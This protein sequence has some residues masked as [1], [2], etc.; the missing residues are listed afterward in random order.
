VLV[1]EDR[2]D[3]SS[4]FMDMLKNDTRLRVEVIDNVAQARDMVRKGNKAAVVVVPEGFSAGAIGIFQGHPITLEL[5]VD[6]SRRAQAGMLEGL[7]TADAYAF[8]QS[9]LTDPA[10]SRKMT[11]E[12][13]E[14]L[15]KAAKT[16]D[17]SP[18]RKAVVGTFLKSLD[19]F[20]SRLPELDDATTDT[21]VGLAA[22]SSE[23][24][25]VAGFAPIA[26][27]PIP[28]TSDEHDDEPNAYAVSFPQGIA[29]GIMACSAA[30]ALSLV[31]ERTHGTL[32]RLAAAPMHRSSVLLGKGLACF[33]ATITTALVLLVIARFGFGVVPVSYGLLA[34]A[35]FSGAIAF[36]GIMMLLSV[37]GK[38]EASAGGIGWAALIVMSMFGGGMVPL[39]FMKGWMQSLSNLSPVK[40]L[41]YSLEGAIWRDLGFSQ[42]LV[43]CG[44]LIAVGCVGYGLGSWLFAR[45]WKA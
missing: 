44:I 11:R 41:I 35:V 42:M 45:S 27:E 34:L 22:S 36:V 30:F 40:W 38:T 19:V 15:D 9:Q 31:T 10:Q 7:I 33:C 39:M 28:L 2:S 6:P 21:P 23:D 16:G 20:M 29:W 12:A 3:A 13:L 5:G 24:G 25:T 18:M 43:P 37:V 32:S 14:S 1:D 8:L 4:Q 17:V 26:I